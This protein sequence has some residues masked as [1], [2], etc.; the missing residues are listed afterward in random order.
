MSGIIKAGQWIS[1]VADQQSVAF[2]FEDMTD[3]AKDYL[4]ETRRQAA[5]ILTKAKQQAAQIAEQAR[6]QGQQT[7]LRE[8]QTALQAKLDQQIETLLPAMEEV[9]RGLQCSQQSWLKHWEGQTVHLAAAIAEHVI[10]RELQHTPEI[11]LDLV[12]EA[13]ELAMGG[14][15]VR[16]HLNPEDHETLGDRIPA[17]AGR[18][19]NLAPTDIVADP[20]IQPG[21]CRVVTEFGEV[22]QQIETQLARIQEELT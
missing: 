13:L 3:K 18:I 4:G 10:R 5:E 22:D 8:A 16:V 20:D 17:V 11:T 7:A 1:S 14:G 9:V 12:R 6:Q 21:G 2:N 19:S 15:K